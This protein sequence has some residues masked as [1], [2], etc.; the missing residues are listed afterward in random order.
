MIGVRPVAIAAAN[1]IAEA[2]I[3]RDSCADIESLV[4]VA[5]A[6]ATL[7]AQTSARLDFRLA[8]AASQPATSLGFT[9]RVGPVL[10]LLTNPTQKMTP[11][12]IIPAAI[13]AMPIYPP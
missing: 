12:E 3:A 9:E 13:S 6:T 2:A 11:N 10:W 7:A 1:N 4:A 8:Q 5:P